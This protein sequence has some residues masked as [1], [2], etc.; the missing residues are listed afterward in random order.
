MPPFGTEKWSG[1]WTICLSACLFSCERD[2]RTDGRYQ[3]YYLP[4]FEVDKR[5]LHRIGICE[6]YSSWFEFSLTMI[7]LYTCHVGLIH[8]ER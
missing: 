3:V 7:R 8:F 4:C 5:F 6:I 2:G 1:S